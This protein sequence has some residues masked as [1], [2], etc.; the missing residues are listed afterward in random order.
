MN[1]FAAALRR[2]TRQKFQ[3]QGQ[4]ALYFVDPAAANP[5]L[6]SVCITDR[7]TAAGDAKA[8]NF[9]GA[10]LEIDAPTIEFLLDQVDPVRNAYI[11]VSHG[12]AYQIDSIMPPEDIT[13]TAK[14][15]R[16]RPDKT[17][18]FPT[19]KV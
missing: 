17:R 2:A 1:R 14:V 16:L 4:S 10:V 5:I 3:H 6:I 9:N 8:T 7:F 11:S 19:P 12:V 15:L 13:V 18:N